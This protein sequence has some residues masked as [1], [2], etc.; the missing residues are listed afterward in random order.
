M[1][2]LLHT[3]GFVQR[4]RGVQ[5]REAEVWEMTGKHYRDGEGRQKR[6]ISPHPSRDAPW[7]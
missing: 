6:G 4:E 3:G 5:E 1:R 7:M 2:A